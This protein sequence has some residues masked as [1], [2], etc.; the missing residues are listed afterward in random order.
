EVEEHDVFRGLRADGFMLALELLHRLQELA[1]TGRDTL[2]VEL[3]G[4]LAPAVEAGLRRRRN[5]WIAVAGAGIERAHQTTARRGQFVDLLRRKVPDPQFF[6]QHDIA[7][8]C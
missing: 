2:L 3:F 1:T 7:P 8:R 5:L 6:R 4:L